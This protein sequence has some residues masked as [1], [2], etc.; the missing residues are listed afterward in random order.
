MYVLLED[1]QGRLTL[2]RLRPWHRFMAWFLTARY[3]RQLASGLQPEAS[4]N[5]A[6]R[7]VQL[8]S[9]KVRRDLAANL[10]LTLA[11]VRSDAHGESQSD[12]PTRMVQVLRSAVELAELAGRLI[13]PGPLPARCVAMVSQLLADGAGPLYEAA[14]RGELC[15]LVERAE[16]EL[17]G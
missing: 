13:Q 17:S 9:M 14:R 1:E 10:L 2:R 12:I 5:L 15:T 11:A 3:D 6:A 8:T 7:A 16:D 4:V